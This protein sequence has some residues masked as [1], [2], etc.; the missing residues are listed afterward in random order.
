[1]AGN[2]NP[3]EARNFDWQKQQRDIAE[4]RKRLSTLSCI[5][6][7]PTINNQDNHYQSQRVTDH[8]KR[9]LSELRRGMQWM[10]EM[11]TNP[12]CQQEIS[13]HLR[14]ALSEKIQTLNCRRME[15]QK[16][17]GQML[18]IVDCKCRE[19]QQLSSQILQTKLEQ[20]RHDMQSKRMEEYAKKQMNRSGNSMSVRNG[21]NGLESCAKFN[22]FAD[23]SNLC[24][25]ALDG[26]HSSNHFGDGTGVG[27]QQSF[28]L[29]SCPPMNGTNNVGHDVLQQFQ[30]EYNRA[31]LNETYSGFESTGAVTPVSNGNGSASNRLNRESQS[32]IKP[33][34][35]THTTSEIQNLRK[36]MNRKVDKI[37]SEINHLTR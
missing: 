27:M 32:A 15:L 26:M 2:G 8:S 21:Q 30:G 14:N 34:H 28:P 17:I 18:D 31:S 19:Y 22:V 5:T 10:N 20:T 33:N 16:E 13:N 11:N 3:D 29:T 4:F 9:Q 35:S 23:A 7:H 36:E 37:M 25:N 24:G 6:E 1:M 12:K